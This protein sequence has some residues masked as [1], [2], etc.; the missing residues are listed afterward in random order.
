VPSGSVRA[1][2]SVGE[3]TGKT[4]GSVPSTESIHQ[5][6]NSV[7]STESVKQTTPTVVPPTTGG[8]AVTPAHGGEVRGATATAGGEVLAAT[9]APILG[10]V[11]GGLLALLGGLG[12]RARR[13]RRP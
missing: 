6:V 4:V 9:G 1:T 7:P 3:S 11:L 5:T 12:L 8:G 2:T 10:G 13:R